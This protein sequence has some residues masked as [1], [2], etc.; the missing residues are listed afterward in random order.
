MPTKTL[1]KMLCASALVGLVATSVACGP[2][3]PP[4][5]VSGEVVVETGP[6]APQQ[7]VIGVA[8][9]PGAVWIEGYWGWNGV[10]YVWVRGHW[11]RARVGWVWVPHRWW[12]GPRGRWHYAPGHWRRG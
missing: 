10:R 9:Y 7:E 2:P 8:P 6:P 5:S 3:L 11:D 12:R 4:G 1:L